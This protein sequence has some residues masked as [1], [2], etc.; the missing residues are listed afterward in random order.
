VAGVFSRPP[1]TRSADPCGNG[2]IA[3][4]LTA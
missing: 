2:T 4:G 1:T 3:C